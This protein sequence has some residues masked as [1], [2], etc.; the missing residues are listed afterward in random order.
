MNTRLA[1]LLCLLLALWSIPARAASPGMPEGQSLYEYYC[2]QCHGY[3]GDART[4]AA[5]YLSPKPRDFSAT[6]PKVLTRATMLRTLE[7]GVPGTAMKAFVRVL[8]ARQ[9]AAVVDYV[10]TAFMQGVPVRRRYHTAENGWA[11]H[12]RTSAAF[13]FATGETPLDVPPETLAP[14]QREGRRL[15]LSAC[16]SCHE[17]ARK[18]EAGATWDRRALSFPRSVETCDGCHESAR[19]LG[20][21]DGKSLAARAHGALDGEAL[22]RRNCAFCHGT[23][24]SGRNW[25]GTFLE[26]HA[27][28]LRER[29]IAALPAEALAAI[30]RDGLPGTSMPAWKGVL[31]DAELLAVAGH[32]RTLVTAHGQDSDLPTTAPPP[33]PAPLEWSARRPGGR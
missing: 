31:S 13:P 2:Y 24:G 23:D 6:S 15:F 14:Q 21:R 9:R 10:R 30:V 25:I 27:R 5:A 29:R 16:V 19:L 7:Q 18:S 22:F 26:P 3:A 17:G 1:T 12:D 8:D 20:A 32:V 11:D 33:R 28:D 4:V